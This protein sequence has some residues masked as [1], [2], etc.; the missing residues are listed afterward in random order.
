MMIM[1]MMMMMVVENEGFF[2]IWK[3]LGRW[4]DERGS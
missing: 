2:E 3:G 4:S 1:I